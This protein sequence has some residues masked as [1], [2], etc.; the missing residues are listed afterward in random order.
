[1]RLDW[2]KYCDQ[3][4]LLAALLEDDIEKLDTYR[5]LKQ[6]VDSYN[7][8]MEESIDSSDEVTFLKKVIEY[9]PP[10]ISGD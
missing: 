5:R 1:M 7:A 9:R 2:C 4:E 6:K 8:E 3:K 10:N